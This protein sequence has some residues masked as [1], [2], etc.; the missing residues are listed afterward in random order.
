MLGTAL[1]AKPFPYPTHFADVIHRC[2]NIQ[3]FLSQGAML[4]IEGHRD[5]ATAGKN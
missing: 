5:L 3:F 4:C 1:G 2:V